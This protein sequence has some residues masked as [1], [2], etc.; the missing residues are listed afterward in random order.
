MPSARRAVVSAT[1]SAVVLLNG[2][3]AIEGTRP[4][5]MSVEAHRRAALSAEERSRHLNAEAEK[6]GRTAM[7]QR[8]TARREAELA[9]AHA[10]AAD[11]LEAIERSACAGIPAHDIAPGVSG[12][13]VVRVSRLD[14]PAAR[15]RKV[16]EGVGF[17]I[18]RNGRSFDSLAG[19]VRCRVARAIAARDESDAF[20]V[21]ETYVR[22]YRDDGDAAIV[23]IVSRDPD[24][25]EQVIRRVQKSGFGFEDAADGGGRDSDE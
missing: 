19:I 16:P 14:R 18:A 23:Q 4:R 15:F 20:S 8:A 9:A 7:H 3:G 10:G 5:D 25:A 12:L 13:D 24:R 6:G 11:H 22:I 2:C 17:V 1:F 21:L